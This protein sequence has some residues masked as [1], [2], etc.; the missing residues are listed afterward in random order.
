MLLMLLAPFLII[1]SNVIAI[2]LEPE[3][4]V[5][6]M[7]KLEYCESR[8]NELAINNKETHGSSYGL[9]QFRLETFEHFGERYGLIHDDIFNPYQQK[10]VAKS[11][12]K[13][14]RGQDHWKNCWRIHNL[15]QYKIN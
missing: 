9:Y 2:T 15:E 12:I 6:L 1:P 14:G 7:D 8:H 5:I 10:A 3:P 4:I 13:D 11:M